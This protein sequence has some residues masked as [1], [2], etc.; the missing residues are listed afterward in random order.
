MQN[1]KIIIEY[2]GTN[3]YGWQRQENLPTIQEKIE[4]AIFNFSQEKVELTGSGRT[5]AG[6]H[7][8]GQVGNFNLKKDTNETIVLKALNAHLKNERISILSCEK[9]SN[10][11]SARFS[12]KQRIY[13]YLILNRNSK[14]A[15]DVNRVWWIPK[16]L[17]VEQ[18]QKAAKYLVGKHDFTSFRATA[19]Q[20]K[21]PIRTIDDIVI[22]KNEDLIYINVKAKSF[23]HHQIR[24]IAGTLAD[25]GKEKI[26]PEKIKEILELKDRTKAGITAPAKGLYFAAVIY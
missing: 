2:D 18:M 1:Y 22:I 20:A 13:Q 9:V 3:Y 23:L 7:A 6:V 14:P 4:E 10:E 25:I 15:I 19:C 26:T 24:N 21:S 12:A 5:D 8:L 17:N 16:K 11:F